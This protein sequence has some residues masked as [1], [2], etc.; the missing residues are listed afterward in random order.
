M[1]FLNKFFS[2]VFRDGTPVR[3]TSSFDRLSEDELQ[4][5]LG[6]ARYGSFMLTGAVRPSYDLQVVPS[7]GYRHDVYNDQE[8]KTKV[9]VLM[10][11]ASGEQLFELFMDL[12]DPLGPV[13][14]VVLET[15]HDR[16]AR[17]H[18]D[19]YREH[20]DMPV[21]KSTLW[22]FEELLLNDGCTGIA[23]LNPSMP[24]EVQFDEHKLLIVY[25]NQLAEYEKVFG[26]R[27]VPCNDEMKFITEAEH[28]HSSSDYF[29]EQFEQLKMRLGIDSY[30]G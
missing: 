11:A 27:T 20:I 17:G 29:A 21:L 25:G 15:S 28:V 10:G 1:G 5:H 8:S 12:L 22:D 9:P 6:V 30:Y 19:L 3:L 23:V 4:A 16:E 7:Q 13:V 14:D 2:N 24:Q 18:V 26:E